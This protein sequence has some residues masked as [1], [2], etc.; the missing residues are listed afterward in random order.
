MALYVQSAIMGVLQ[1][2]IYGLI[3]LGLTLIFG[4]MK[5]INFAHGQTLMIAMYLTFFLTTILNVNPYFSIIIT[6]PIMFIFGILLFKGLIQHVLKAEE[7]NQIL[8]TVGIGLVLQNLA[9]MFFSADFR[10]ISNDMT[11][12]AFYFLDMSISYPH[13]IGFLISA[14]TTIILFWILNR[15]RL[16]RQIR[17]A[18]E[19]EEAAQLVGI[20]VKKIYSI[21]FA[22]GISCLAISAATLV[23]IYYTAPD[24]GTLF[25]LKAF[26]I[27]VLGGLGNFVGALV[28][29]I[30]IGVVEALGATVIPGSLA[31]I[32]SF[33]VFIFI[34]LFR[35]QGL[36]TKR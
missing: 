9:L 16:G 4:V 32:L 29:G 28:G 33:I 20:N 17:S 14:I 3:A 27:V 18:S 13:V 26:V 36:F 34:L 31:P 1:G 5:I 30:I 23:P 22:I 19:N 21:S 2:S 8:L 15:T 10:T 35:P 6:V 7:S 12:K 25:T 11:R 24:V